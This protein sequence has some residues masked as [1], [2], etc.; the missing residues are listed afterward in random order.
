MEYFKN[1]K[2][3][4]K[5]AFQAMLAHGS[6]TVIDE[7]ALPAYAHTNKLIDWLFWQRLKIAE[8][9][10]LQQ[11]P[12]KGL[13]LDFGCG[14]GVFSELMQQHQFQVTALDQI[15]TPAKQLEAHIKFHSDIQ[16][17]EGN[18]SPHSFEKHTFDVIVALDVLEHVDNL[19]TYLTLLKSFLKKEGVLVISGPTENWLYRLGRHI[20]GQNFSGHYHIHSIYDVK[21]KI[22]PLFD[23]KQCQRL[24]FPLTLFEIFY[25][26]PKIS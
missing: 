4:F 2:R 25:A 6:D 18:L 17:I 8:K 22:N 1:N 19:T 3:R 9:M 21:E 24:Y 5:S 20:A 14:S 11:M 12:N 16:F 23:I 26:Y 13:L 15:L 7:A 10:I